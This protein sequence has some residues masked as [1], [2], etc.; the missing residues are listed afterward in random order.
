MARIDS[1]VVSWSRTRVQPSRL[2]ARAGSPRLGAETAYRAAWDEPAANPEWQRPWVDDA[3]YSRFW[4]RELGGAY[5]SAAGSKAWR[6]QAP[7]RRVETHTLTTTLPGVALWCDQYLYPT[8]SGV[9]VQAELHLSGTPAELLAVVAGLSSNPVVHLDGAPPRTMAAVVTAL[10]DDMDRVVLGAPDPNAVTAPNLRTV[11]VVTGGTGWTPTP[12]VQGAELHRFLV[13][14]CLR[15]TAP[16]TGVVP[17]PAAIMMEASTRFGD[18]VRVAVGDGQAVWS[19]TQL[20]DPVSSARLECYHR[21]LALAA[22][23]TAVL[24]DTVRWAA[25]LPIANLTGD[26]QEAVKVVLSILGRLY[27]KADGVYA[28]SLV[29]RQIDAS[30]LVEAVNTLRVQLGVG[31]PM[32]SPNPA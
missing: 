11:A 4:S 30:G 24:L 12:I 32:F 16:L 2:V 27:G 5:R 14:L 17:E 31:G 25:Q 21:N 8:G 22:M 6:V 20:A 23:R 19:P 26:V 13:G 28:S 10:L 9:V 15:S 7:L 29:R 1:A 3:E 18:T